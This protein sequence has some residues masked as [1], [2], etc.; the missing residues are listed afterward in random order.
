M[1]YLWTGLEVVVLDLVILVGLVLVIRKGL[2][3]MGLGSMMP[4]A[5]PAA[6]RRPAPAH[7]GGSR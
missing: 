3:Q 7:S 5:K 4:A 2:K 1:I 6:K